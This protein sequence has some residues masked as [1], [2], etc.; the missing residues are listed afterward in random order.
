MLSSFLLVQSTHLS[1]QARVAHWTARI[2]CTPLHKRWLHKGPRDTVGGHFH[3]DECNFERLGLKPS[4]LTALRLAFP[5]IKHP[6]PIQQQ[7]IGAV[8]EGQNVLLKDKTGTGKSFAAVLALLSQKRGKAYWSNVP[9]LTAPVPPV[10]SLVLV[11]HRDLA[12]Q[13]FHWIERMHRYL[14]PKEPLPSLAQVFVRDSSTPLESQLEPIQ[15]TPPHILIGTPQ[16][17][18]DVMQADPKALPFDRLATVLVDEVDYLIETVPTMA[19]KYAVAKIEKRIARHPGP[20]RLLLNHIYSTNVQGNDMQIHSKQ[21]NKGLRS[22]QQTDDSR[23][24]LVMMSATLRN[25]LRRFLLADSGWLPSESGKLV[26]ITGEVSPHNPK[27]RQ[28][29]SE[30]DAADTVGGQGIQHHVIVVS[31]KG[32]IANISGAVDAPSEESRPE[33]SSEKS[34]EMPPL[35]GS[36]QVP[37]VELELGT[38]VLPGLILFADTPSPF[39]PD[40]LEGIAAAFALDVPSVGLLVLPSN[41]PV[42]RAVCDLRLL[43]VNTHALDVVKDETGRVHLMR[44]DFGVATENPTLLVSTLASTRGLDLPELT[45]VFILGVLD[46][47]A[48]DSYLHVAGRVGRFGRGGKV[49]SVVADR[50]EETLDNGKKRVRDEP[51]LIG[52]LLRKAGIKPTRFEHFD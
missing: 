52:A 28:T 10:T 16:A 2:A 7:F 14:T 34:G 21:T 32:N 18:W 38:F 29:S 8:L 19:D 45:H 41:A 37:D 23:P 44:Q 15:H 3:P 11:P 1:V 50:H 49:V 35:P 26:R 4:V 46:N 42:Q 31:D 51:R 43:G 17:L 24:Q 36:P 40:A 27:S 47:G 5:S 48:G 30:G 33:T 25:H 6:T 12:Y 13:F 9:G 22:R 39:N 20:T